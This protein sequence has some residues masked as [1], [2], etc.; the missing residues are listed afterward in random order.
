MLRP[1]PRPPP[2]PHL[3]ACRPPDTPAA[4]APPQ[5]DVTD[6]SGSCMPCSLSGLWNQRLTA[7]MNGEQQHL[8]QVDEQQGAPNRWAQGPGAAR[9][10]ARRPALPA[11][12]YS[13][14]CPRLAG[15]SRQ[16][17]ASAAAA[18]PGSAGIALQP[19]PA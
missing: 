14:P 8:W 12:S 10:A 2:A 16:G 5:G 19:G 18:A 9:S 6:A 15:A 11:A 17:A 13:Q 7:V 1:R 4:C 3:P